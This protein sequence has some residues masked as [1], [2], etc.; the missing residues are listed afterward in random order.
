MHG[1]GII[2]MIAIVET[3]SQANELL[4]AVWYFLS[5]HSAKGR[6]ISRGA[7]SFIFIR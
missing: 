6:D 1:A 3:E 2:G 5:Q 7:R 4:Y